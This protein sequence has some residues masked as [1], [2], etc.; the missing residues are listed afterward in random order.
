AGTSTAGSGTIS[1]Y[2]WNLAGTPIAG[3]TTSTYTATAA[4]SY[5][6]TVTNTNNCFT[7]SAATNVTVNALPTIALGANPA[8]CRGITTANLPYSATTGS[9]NQYSID[10]DA[11]ANTA[12]F[13]DVTNAALPASSIVLTVPAA[14]PA[15]TYN[16]TLTVRNSTTGCVSNA[17]PI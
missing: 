15:T 11:T 17:S 4:G 12:G 3:A 13:S 9:P 6:V 16:A 8:V 7:P 14:V 2:Q 10:Y 5:T 1:G